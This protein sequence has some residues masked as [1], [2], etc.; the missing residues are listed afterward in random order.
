[1]FIITNHH[2]ITSIF[3]HIA[4]LIC[5]AW[6]RPSWHF[7]QLFADNNFKQMIP[8][9]RRLNNILGTNCIFLTNFPSIVFDFFC[10]IPWVLGYCGSDHNSII[11]EITL[12]QPVTGS[13]YQPPRVQIAFWNWGAWIRFVRSANFFL[14]SPQYISKPPNFRG[15]GY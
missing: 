2:I 7:F 10:I 11:S 3:I 6:W 12:P 8:V 13:M 9:H 1:M 14:S 15:F 4:Y 5:C